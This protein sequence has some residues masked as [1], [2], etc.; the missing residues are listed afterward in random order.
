MKRTL[1]LTLAL[2]CIAA[3]GGGGDNGGQTPTHPG[4]L[5]VSYFQGG[6]EPGALLLTITGG[7]VE[8][9]TA[10]GGQQVSFSSPFAGTTKVVVIGTLTNGD[11]LR[12]RVPDVSQSTSYTARVDQAAD[13]VSFAL[14]EPGRYTL[15]VHR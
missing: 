2:G 1:S 11:L 14:V 4:D 10:L 3:C 6:P 9:V 8:N 5:L 7:K 13:K 12:V 15:T